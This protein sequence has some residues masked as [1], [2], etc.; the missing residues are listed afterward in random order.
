MTKNRRWK[1]PNDAHAGV[2]AP[3][4]MRKVDVRRYCLPC[5][6]EAGVLVERECPAQERERA[7]REEGRRKARTRTRKAEGRRRETQARERAARKSEREH[8]LGIHV[9][10]HF[11]KV[12]RTPVVEEALEN[13]E[14][15]SPTVRVRRRRGGNYATGRAYYRSSR[16]VL[17]LPVDCTWGQLATLVA[18]EIAHVCTADEEHHGP[19]WRD[20][21]LSILGEAYGLK[22]SWPVKGG[23]SIRYDEAH[24]V[25]E[26]M[27]DEGLGVSASAY[28][29]A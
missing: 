3:A 12:L 16:I 24:R 18:H 22:T 5:S 21:F 8:V 15:P 25:F 9:P 11:A 4:R 13:L 28:S 17:T 2:L 10:T 1:C 7:R 20:M 23:K 14:R 27:I 26:K 6:E 19:A 29:Q